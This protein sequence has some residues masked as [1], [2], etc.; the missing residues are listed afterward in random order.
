MPTHIDVIDKYL[1]EAVDKQEK[2]ATDIIKK[3]SGAKVNK[4]NKRVHVEFVLQKAL[5]ERE[6][7][8]MKKIDDIMDEL[9]KV[10]GKKA[11]VSFNGMRKFT[12]EE[13]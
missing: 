3:I 2:K 7:E 13:I 6:L 8:N 11:H 4:I 9:E 1:N 5:D 12:V 10:Y